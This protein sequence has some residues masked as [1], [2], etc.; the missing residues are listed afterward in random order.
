M[1]SVR[2]AIVVTGFVSAIFISPWLTIACMIALSIR[3]R[4]IEVLGLGLLVDL[5][6]LPYDTF[7]YSFP[8][9]TLLALILVWGL[10]PLRLEFMN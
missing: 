10:E 2:I 7:W 3:Y 9:T 8:L 6:W 4:A 5:L 1:S